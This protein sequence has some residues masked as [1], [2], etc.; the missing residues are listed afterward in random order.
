MSIVTMSDL[1]RFPFDRAAE[2]KTEKRFSLGFAITST[3]FAVFVAAITGTWIS[4][5]IAGSYG[6]KI[7]SLTSQLSQDRAEQ[8]QQIDEIS[9][10][11]QRESNQ[12][13]AQSAQIQALQESLKIEHAER[14]ELERHMGEGG[15]TGGLK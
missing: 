7:D 6:A 2:S 9:I 12:I 8:R 1:R 15:R 11:V 10:T 3:V 14:I 5:Q 4:G 13:A